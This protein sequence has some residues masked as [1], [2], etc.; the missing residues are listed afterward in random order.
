MEQKY[1]NAQ[2]RVNTKL[3]QCI[4]EGYSTHTLHSTSDEQRIIQGRF[5]EIS[6]FLLSA[7]WGQLPARPTRS[8]FPL[9]PASTQRFLD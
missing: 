5:K 1:G 9:R 2:P 3:M 6:H 4:G 7:E 8:S